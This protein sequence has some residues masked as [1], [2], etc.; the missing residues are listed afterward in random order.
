[1]IFIDSNEPDEIKEILETLKLPVRKRH[2]IINEEL[3]ITVDYIIKVKD[4]VV[5][6]ERK[7]WTDLVASI[8]DGRYSQQRYFLYKTFPLSYFVIVGS[9]EDFRDVL[10]YRK[11]HINA[12]LGVLVSTPLK[13][14]GKVNIIQV[15]D[16]MQFCLILK[17]IH[18]TLEKEKIEVIPK[19]VVRK[20]DYDE[21]KIMMLACVPGIGVETAKKLIEKYK[22]I[23]NIVKASK[24]ELSEV[25]GS[26]RAE[27]L[28]SFIHY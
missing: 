16:T 9:D 18:Q 26:K 10:K 4:K 27:K 23:E 22:T 6:V 15:K 17:L 1:M 3:N 21:L 8:E 14:M 11:I 5:A 12:L 19:P 24:K 25:I 2:N 13:T 20:S 28:Y 7:T